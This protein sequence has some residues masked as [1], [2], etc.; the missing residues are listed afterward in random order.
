MQHH[1]VIRKGNLT[2]KLRVIFDASC[3]TDTGI[4]LNDV[5]LVGPTI[6][7]D[8]FWIVVRFRKYPVVMK[9]DILKMDRQIITQE[10]QNI[11][12]AL[13]RDDS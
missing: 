1:L 6:Q 12:N 13:W 4:S 5:Q 7:E 10:S 11:C 8:S 9:A 2:T 3:K